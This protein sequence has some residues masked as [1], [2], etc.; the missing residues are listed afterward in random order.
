[1]LIFKAGI[2]FS[3]SADSCQ[4]VC[5]LEM[6]RLTVM[7]FHHTQHVTMAI[8]KSSIPSHENDASKNQFQNGIDFSQGIDSVESLPGVIKSIKI[9]AQGPHFKRLRSPR[10]GFEESIPST[11]ICSLTG[12]YDKLGSPT[13]PPGWESI[14]G[15]LTRFT[16]TGS[17]F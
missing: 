10:I 1:M 12:R 14:P 2:D 4:I 16:T 6:C 15:L 7:P 5:M 3:S 9:Q 13:G 11:F 17:G 8:M